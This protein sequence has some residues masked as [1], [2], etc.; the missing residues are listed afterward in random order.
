M[1]EMPATKDKSIQFNDIS[2]RRANRSKVEIIA[3]I[4]YHCT[5]G[6]SLKKTNIMQRA[7]L[8]TK[9]INLYLK[10]MV[11]LQLLKRQDKGYYVVTD[12]GM[13]VLTMY[14]RIRELIGQ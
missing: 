6:E 1:T 3:D 2:G 4:L 13:D 12:R 11:A 9:M 8:S 7:N 10:D 14:H 5:S